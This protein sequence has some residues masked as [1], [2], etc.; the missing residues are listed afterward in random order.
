MHPRVSVSAISTYRLSL[1]E[2]LGF[3]AAHGIDHVG[4][5][6]AKL[7]AHGWDA[8]ARLVARACEGGLRVGNLIGLGPFH[9]A[10][11]DRWEEQ[12]ARL[13][14]AVD[15]AAATGAGCMV[16]TT[17]PA[18][19][20]TW[21]EAA[22]ALAEAL[23]PVLREAAARRVRFAIEH[24]NPLR[25]DVGFV[26]TLRDAL[27][28]AGRLGTGVCMEVN[29]CWAER[30]LAATVRDG[31]DRIALVQ[32]SDFRVGTHCTPDR[33]VPGDGDVPLARIVGLLLRAGY[34][35]PFDVE[36][37]GP[38]IEE[39]GYASAVPRAVAAVEALLRDLGE[40]AGASDG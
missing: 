9:L 29:A 28:L 15:L 34:T 14:R 38:R 37:V 5:S 32:L 10:R 7:E 40:G 17:G 21:E 19:P 30:A 35:G 26:H 25:V 6:V 18:A 39:E 31:V 12:R 27:D 20:L 22:D 16:F 4:V 3:W 36:L 11:P 8:G 2:D 33:L 23:A 24:T 13:V 1:A